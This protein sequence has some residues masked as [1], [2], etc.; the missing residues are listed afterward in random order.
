ML[1]NS[2]MSMLFAIGFVF[3]CVPSVYGATL[4]TKPDIG[5]TGK[6]S[7]TGTCDL[8]VAG[9]TDKKIKP[10]DK[11][12]VQGQEVP[13]T[14]DESCSKPERSVGTATGINADFLIKITG[15]YCEGGG[16]GGHDHGGHV[17]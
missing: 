6:I 7:G 13:I 10:E 17:A 9:P 14:L 11:V 1:R 8:R 12:W 15:S 2:L 5:G 4:D 16:G 3:M